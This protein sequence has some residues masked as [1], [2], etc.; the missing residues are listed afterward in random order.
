MNANA[1]LKKVCANVMKCA[2]EVLDWNNAATK[3]LEEKEKQWKAVNQKLQ[4]AMYECDS[5]KRVR[6]ETCL[7]PFN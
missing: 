5:L 2:K 1:F 7:F 3:S 6:G 4:A